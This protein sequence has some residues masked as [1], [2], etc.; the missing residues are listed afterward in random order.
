MASVV[1]TGQVVVSSQVDLSAKA[2]GG[3]KEAKD[4]FLQFGFR[5]RSLKV[6]GA[7]RASEEA[8]YA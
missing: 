6:A 2:S 5:E 8:A 4:I 7:R 1:G 3:P